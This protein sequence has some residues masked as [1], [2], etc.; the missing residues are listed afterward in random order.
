MT[1]WDFHDRKRAQ[2]MQLFTQVRSE[3]DRKIFFSMLKKN[4]S[5]FCYMPKLQTLLFYEQK[6]KQ[7]AES[8]GRC[9]S[10]PW[11]PTG[12]SQRENMEWAL[13]TILSYGTEL[14]M[15]G[16]TD[17]WTGTNSPALEVKL[18]NLRPS[19]MNSARCA[20]SCKGPIFEPPT[21]SPT[22]GYP[23]HSLLLCLRCRE[24]HVLWWENSIALPSKLQA[25]FE[26]LTRCQLELSHDVLHTT[27]VKW[28]AWC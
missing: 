17:G 19:T 6:I 24:S 18:F 2:H 23:G 22:G 5:L 16:R 9:T 20:G 25:Q 3:S 14:V 28:K 21:S 8:H 26:G 27:E 12:A 4:V 10:T 11:F 1:C 7:T 13:C 15:V